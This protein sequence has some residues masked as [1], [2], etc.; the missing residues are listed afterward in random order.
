[1]GDPRPSGA[2]PDADRRRLAR[3]VKAYDIRGLVPD[4]LDSG[5]A[6]RL[7]AAVADVLEAPAVVVGRDMRPSSSPLATAFADGVMTR[8]ADVVDIGLAATDMVYFASGHL[9][10]PAAM[11]TASH[12]PA[13][14]NG[15]KLC[16]AGA[17]PVSIDTGLEQIRDAAGDGPLAS[18]TT[19][20]SRRSE[21]VLD[22][23]ADHVRSFVELERMR[24][25]RVVVDAANGMAGWVVPAVFDGLPV[26]LE[27]LYF[28]LDGT[29]PNH[30]ADPSDPANL[31]DLRQA[32]RHTGA[33]LGL[34]FDG[35]ADRA[36][37]VDER[38]VPVAPSLVGAIVAERMLIKNPGS[39][40]LYNLI[41]SR[42]VPETITEA[43]GRPVRTRVGHS[44]IKAR[45]AETGAAFACEHS[46]HYYFRDN[47]RADSGLIAALLLLEAVGVAD[48]PLSEVVSPYERYSQSGEINFTVDDQQAVL[49]RVA[50]HFADHPVEWTDGLSVTTSR[51]WFNLRPSNTE[52]LLRLNVEGDDQ[53]AMEGLRDRVADLIRNGDG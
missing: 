53:A 2:L 46:G 27:P 44:F 11:F 28:E 8:G 32:V 16:R 42:A 7:G 13:S 37:A 52:P 20:G 38:G 51:G 30:P 14:Y 50:R 6:H 23:Y 21:D 31:T 26:E 15:I 25:L 24:G 34:A 19:R 35:D 47:Y 9:D 18:A 10:L 4:E 22:R 40:V 5:L 39:V 29:F 43:G 36:F 48:R 41:C 1:M 33:D 49:R 17:A 12:N 45:M 3:I